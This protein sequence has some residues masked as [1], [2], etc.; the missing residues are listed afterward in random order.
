MSTP[1]QVFA[2]HDDRMLEGD[3]QQV[4]TDFNQFFSKDRLE[5]AAISQERLRL[6]RELHDGVLQSLTGVSLQ[7]E[8]LARLIDE[9]PHAARKRLNDIEQLIG[10]E[11]RE[12]R[13]WIEKL[14]PAGLIA[15]ASCDDLAEV[16]RTLCQRV[17][18]GWGLVVRLTVSG[19]KAVPRMIGDEIYRL[20]QEGLSNIAR[21]AHAQV[22]RVEV[23]LAHDHVRIVIA[24]DGRGFSFHGRYDLAALTEKRVGP[25]S[26]KARVAS[27]VGDLVLTST[28]SGSHIEI[29]LPL[30]PSLSMRARFATTRT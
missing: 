9:N 27:L 8:A 14:K 17:E 26:L 3:A 7:L 28:L 23:C 11:Q 16:L 10:E 13:A 4:A 19:G 20:V 25:A 24:D 12:L 18:R 30:N 6:A 1:K 29:K 15:M 22:G 21:H 2:F 5:R